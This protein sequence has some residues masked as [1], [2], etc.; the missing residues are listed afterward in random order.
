MRRIN[1]AMI[2]AAGL[3]TRMRPLTL[4]TPKPLIKV[5]GRTLL[6]HALDELRPAG[7][8]TAV[9]NVHYLA[10]Q[11]E[12]HCAARQDMEIVISDERDC[13]LET[14][15]GVRKAL[16]QLGADFAVLNSDNIWLANGM[17]ALVQLL[18]HWNP[19]TMDSLLLLARR[20]TAVGYTRAG[21]F[22]L[23]SDGRLMRRSDATAPYVYAS[24][25]ISQRR[26]FARLPDGPVSTNVAWD[27]SIKNGRLY[28]YLFDGIWCDIGTPGSIALAEAL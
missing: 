24:I 9:V 20:E 6:D 7:I 13:L 21:D 16:P 28:G 12:A 3:G 8:G 27:E 4:A 5:R 17:S 1:S 14:G 2:L 18:P 26:Q 19:E 15:G 23:G 25:Y 22:E 11:V 10:A